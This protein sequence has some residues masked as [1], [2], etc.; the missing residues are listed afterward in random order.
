MLSR[1]KFAGAA[2]MLGV[3]ATLP[4]V[5]CTTGWIDTAIQ[6]IP[7]VEQIIN[8]VVSI[9]AL[10]TGNVL[11]TPAAIATIDMAS[12]AVAADL[13]VLKALLNDYNNTPGV[14]VIQRI[15][16][17]L[18]EIEANLHTILTVPGVPVSSTL[19]AIISS[20]IGLA[21]TVVSSVQLLIPNSKKSLALKASGAPRPP[22][23]LMKSSDIKFS[24]NAVLKSN[25]Y[26]QFAIK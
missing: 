24:Y 18:Q 12:K 8:T 26:P 6:D 17:T 1:R 5:G 19:Y 4:F 23:Q 25:G 21:L 2:F 14:S 9:A 16:Q 7:V 3:S 13:L 10:S 22:V 20:G 15:D 11:L